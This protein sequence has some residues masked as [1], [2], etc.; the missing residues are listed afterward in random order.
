MSAYVVKTLEYY[1]QPFNP[2]KPF[3]V[4]S[5]FTSPMISEFFN[6]LF[7]ISLLVKEKPEKI[8]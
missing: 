3:R 8:N 1:L 5:Q 4:C 6:L 7:S 2:L